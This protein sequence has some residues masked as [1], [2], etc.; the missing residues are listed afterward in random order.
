M[1]RKSE[2]EQL[3]ERTNNLLADLQRKAKNGEKERASLLTAM[4]LLVA[5]SNVIVKD[6]DPLNCNP[7]SEPGNHEQN[8][9][10]GVT[11]ENK[12]GESEHS[13]N[14]SENNRYSIV[15]DVH[16]SETKLNQVYKDELKSQQSWKR[17][18][19][20]DVTIVGDSMFKYVNLARLRKS[21]KRNVIVKACITTL[22]QP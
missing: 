21:L 13:T 9:T 8:S 4:Q 7:A 16:S 10:G 2:N 6:N 20:I 5:E 15:S 12:S 11:S 22:S 18:Q 3:I 19:H 14:Q 17:E 1:N